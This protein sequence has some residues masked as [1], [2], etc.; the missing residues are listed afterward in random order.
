M[1]QIVI[2]TFG[3]ALLISCDTPMTKYDSFNP[4]QEWL[5]NNGIHINAHGG[6]ILYY[7]E[8][9]VEN[10]SIRK[11]QIQLFK[12]MKEDMIKDR[13]LNEDFLIN[14]LYKYWLNELGIKE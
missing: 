5:N 8:N 10:D 12:L 14:D 2:L 6:G 1:K 13:G 7:D 11:E 4:G 9:Y 3:L